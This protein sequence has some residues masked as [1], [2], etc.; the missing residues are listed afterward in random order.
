LGSNVAESPTPTRD[1][2]PDDPSIRRAS[3]LLSLGIG[4][5]GLIVLFGLVTRGSLLDWALAGA[6]AIAAGAAYSYHESIGRLGERRR[7]EVEAYARLLQ[8]LSRSLSPEAVLGA[9]V[10]EL[11]ASTDADHLVVV[12]R[13]PDAR[14]LEA[15]LVSRRPGVPDATTLL[16]IADLEDPVHVAGDAAAE[17]EI[18]GQAD[19]E[20]VGVPILPDEEPIPLPVFVNAAATDASE[21][22]ATDAV[23]AQP[24]A[25][26]IADPIP[27]PRHNGS[28]LSGQSEPPGWLASVRPRALVGGTWSAAR[29]LGVGD[30]IAR[31]RGGPE[32]GDAA[33][34]PISSID[35]VARA[36]AERI[37]D[38]AGTVYGLG[39]L[40]AAPLLAGAR[41]VGAIVLSR[42]SREPWPDSARRLLDAAALESAVALER[43]YTVREA[44]ARAATD[45]LTGLPN[46][47]YFDEFCGLLARR[48][49]A[50]DAVGVLMIDIDRF[51]AL[52]DRYGHQVG[53]EVLKAVA[54]AIAAAVRDDDVPARVGGEEFAVLLRN[55]GHGVAAE[56]GE[57]VRQAVGALDLRSHGV[58]RVSVS[59]GVAVAQG[60][61]EAIGQIVDRADR[62]LYR[63]KRTGRDRVVTAA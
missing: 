7:S 12:R 49:R 54:G 35:P 31:L 30:A 60:A 32:G 25:A 22:A 50:G 17:A 57:R 48:R 29:L 55:P 43:A 27:Y 16:P 42:R 10:E 5:T 2:A 56:V 40:I 53:D 19:R 3:L 26:T 11:A 38:R 8:G 61:D 9:I 6:V 58:D 21:S 28:R 47:R 33:E 18:P 46:R 15:R 51:K 62:A 37:A 24:A 52:N 59:V 39:N 1:V 14:I 44:E 63:A 36:I 23:T 13:R 4:A 41:P 45:P 20:P 34:A